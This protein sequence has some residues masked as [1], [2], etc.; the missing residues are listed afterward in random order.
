MSA[1]E[2]QGVFSSATETAK[3]RAR[4]RE[5]EARLQTDDI[6]IEIEHGKA[7]FV[8]GNDTR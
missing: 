4:I 3:L 1:D 5:L 2:L 7:V 8:R 6:D